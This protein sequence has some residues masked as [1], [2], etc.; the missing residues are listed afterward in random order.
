MAITIPFGKIQQHL[1]SMFNKQHT[2]EAV[3]SETWSTGEKNNLIQF[4]DKILIQNIQSICNKIDILEDFVQS[5]PD[6]QI[7]CF[8]ETWLSSEK[9]ELIHLTNYQV[10]ASYCRTSRTGG[11]VCILLKNNME[12]L[13]LKE[14]SHMSIEYVVEICAVELIN[15]NIILLTLYY[16]GKKEDLF[17]EKIKTILDYINKKFSKHKII[18]GGDFNVD[19][20][21]KNIKNDTTKRN[22]SNKLSDLMLQYNLHQQIHSPTRVTKTSSTCLDLVYLNFSDANLQINVQ[23]LGLSDHRGTIINLNLSKQN[24]Q[25]MWYTEKRQYNKNNI[26][27][28]KLALESLDWENIL[29]NNKDINYNYNTFHQTLINNLDNC[30]PKKVIKIKNNYKKHWLTVGIKKSCYNKRL[31]KSHIIRSNNKILTDYYKKYEKILKKV[32]T[33]SKKLHY[34]NKIKKSNNKIKTMWHIVRERTNK[35]KLKLNSNIKLNINNQ[36]SSNPKQ[37]A[38]KFNDYF[39]NIGETIHPEAKGLPVLHPSEN[40]MFLSRVDF[41]ETLKILKS[42]KNK[43][44][45]GVDDIPPTL[46]KQCASALAYPLTLLVNQAFEEGAFPDILKHS[47]VKPIYKKG[48]QTDPGNYRPIALLPTASKIFE[49]ALYDRIYKFCEKYNIF[50]ES[51]NGFRKN[52]STVLAINNY[53]QKIHNIINDKKYAIGIL[54]DMSKA[55]DTVQYNILLNKLYDIGIR[56]PCYNLLKSYLHNRTQTVEIEYYN[57]KQH[58]IEK[59]RS[60]TKTVK[61]SIPQ[62][63]VLGCL[64]FLIYIN[65]FAEALNEYCVMFADDI[66]ILISSQSSIDLKEKINSILLKTTDWLTKHNLKI[67]FSKTKIMPFHPYQKPKLD[68]KIDNHGF[69]IDTVNEHTL[70]GLIIDTHITWKPHIEKLHRKLSS[71]LYALREVKKTTDVSTAITTYYAYAYAWLSYGIVLWGGSTDAP[72]LLTKQKQLIRIIANIKNT[73][74]CKPYFKKYNIL[75]LPCIYILELCKLVKKYPS[76]YTKR[77]D[78]MSRNLRPRNKLVIPTSKLKSHSSSPLAMSIRIFNKLPDSIK[79]IQDE[80]PFINKLKQLLINKC[81]YSISDF[82]DDKNIICNIDL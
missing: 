45:H 30:I 8:T 51:Q 53:I 6:Y 73:E 25:K 70:L 82:L 24:K 9:L 14:I 61:A 58:K 18:L 37:V 79:N 7:L 21:Q 69:T 15:Y 29:K 3:C 32:I 33:T 50:S 11:G 46:F 1:Q 40:S 17:Y 23:E 35:I 16:N 10:A 78:V 27:N 65:D 72:S 71:F 13:E 36:I 2:T 19:M 63:S 38:D 5:N 26:E 31:L 42:L 75:S 12:Y 74:S 4:H 52:K 68:I 34:I 54:L 67:N 56:G 76:F 47:L 64:M 28:F 49:K 43:L 57:D 62:G 59:I 39:T 81:Y 55:Y 20:L 80:K 41:E 48:I 44:S 66:S 77:D 60:D 22:K